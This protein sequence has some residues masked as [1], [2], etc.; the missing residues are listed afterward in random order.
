MNLAGKSGTVIN[1][2]DLHRVATRLGEQGDVPALLIRNRLGGIAQ[3]VQQDLLDLDLIDED[4]DL[5]EIA[6]QF[7]ASPSLLG[8]EERQLRRLLD[9]RRDRLDPLLAVAARHE[10][11]PALGDLPG[12]DRL[13][14]GPLYGVAKSGEWGS[15]PRFRRALAASM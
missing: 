5:C 1:Y 11:A 6:P 10:P 8:T 14:A 13:L 2:A 9:Q 3:Q 4:G 12:S 15:P 7:D